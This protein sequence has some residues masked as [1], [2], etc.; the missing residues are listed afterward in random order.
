VTYIEETK[1]K[2]PEKTQDLVNSLR[3]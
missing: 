1:K 2:D 3:K